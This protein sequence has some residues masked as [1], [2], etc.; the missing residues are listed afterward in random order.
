MN[1]PPPLLLHPDLNCS[2]YC[3]AKT[4]AAMQSD[5]LGQ[6]FLKLEIATMMHIKVYSAHTIYSNMYQQPASCQIKSNYTYLKV[7]YDK[8]IS[9]AA[10]PQHLMR[11]RLWLRLWKNYAAR[12]PAPI[13]TNSLRLI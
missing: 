4:A 2:L 13:S 8:F 9:S 1:A 3:T 12:A 11:L 10:E 6:E 5:A 7:L